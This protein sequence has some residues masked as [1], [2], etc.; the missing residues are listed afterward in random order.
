MPALQSRNITYRY[1][2]QDQV[3]VCYLQMFLMLT[4]EGEKTQNFLLLC[5]FTFEVFFLTRVRVGVSGWE[6]QDQDDEKGGEHSDSHG[7]GHDESF[8]ELMIHQ[9]IHTIEYEWVRG[10]R[11]E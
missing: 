11:R 5:V 1:H 9:G 6:V 8:G 7:H 3:D 4:V 10:E 2:S